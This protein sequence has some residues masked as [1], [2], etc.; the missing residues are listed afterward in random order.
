[1]EPKIFISKK[2]QRIVKKGFVEK[3][4]LNKGILIISDSKTSGAHDVYQVLL[5]KPSSKK[6]R[7]YTNSKEKLEKL[8]LNTFVEK[9]N[10][11][12]LVSIKN[13]AALYI[14]ESEKKDY[15]AIKVKA[16]I[17]PKVLVDDNNLLSYSQFKNK[18]KKSIELTD[19]MCF[20]FEK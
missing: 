9:M 14:L 1:M 5:G 19:F 3:N 4:I 6:L 15:D 12:V 11:C 16:H 13:L 7:I 10:L 2:A 20:D 18:C 17:W 8:F